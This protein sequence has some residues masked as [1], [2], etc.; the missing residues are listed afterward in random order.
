MQLDRR[1]WSISGIT[2]GGDETG[3]KGRMVGNQETAPTYSSLAHPVE[4]TRHGAAARRKSRMRD[5]LWRR[6][7]CTRLHLHTAS[8]TEGRHCRKGERE[9]EKSWKFNIV[10]RFFEVAWTIY[11]RTFREF[12]RNQANVFHFPEI[13]RNIFHI[14]PGNIQGVS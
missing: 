10:D 13:F 5:D 3:G 9:R 1:G 11:F 14:F 12:R 7:T 4:R 6:A 2:R 8:S